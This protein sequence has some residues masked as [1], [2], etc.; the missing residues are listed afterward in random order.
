MVN[1][2]EKYNSKKFLQASNS[3]Q[4]KRLCGNSQKARQTEVLAT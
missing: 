1:R 4:A 2:Q 3:I